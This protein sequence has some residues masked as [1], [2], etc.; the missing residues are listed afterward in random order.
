MRGR[1]PVSILGATGAVGQRYV[2][3][4]ADHPWFEIA[5]LAASERSTG[6]RYAEACRWVLDMPMPEAVRDMPVLPVDTSLPGRLIFSGLPGDLAGQVEEDLARAGFA[7]CS[8]AS[9]HRMDADVPLVIPEVNPDHVELI[10][11]Q[12]AGRNWD[13]LLVTNPNCST[14][15]LALALA[16]LWKEFVIR[17]LHVVT[18]QA[19]SGAGYPGVPSM[20]IIDNVVPYIGGEEDKVQTEPQKLLGTLSDGVIAQA[21]FPVSA[22]CTRV[23]VLEGHM[24]CVSV[25]LEKNVSLDEVKEAWRAYRSEPQERQLPSAPDAP[26]VLMEEA[27]RP[28]HRKDR[29]A[30]DG[31][32]VT[33]GRVQK[34]PVMGLKFVAL[35]HNTVRGAAGGSLELAELLVARGLVE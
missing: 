4:L 29:D 1:I 35:G 9:A 17:R 15:V 32:A 11:T 28:Q 22:Q 12:R 23:P 5:G 18:L 26:I 25:E 33:I 19:L 21:D 24:L 7:V 2:S 31:M 34:C 20:D 14:T 30:G 13:G 8:N 16:P 3:L 27:D 6:R 10:P